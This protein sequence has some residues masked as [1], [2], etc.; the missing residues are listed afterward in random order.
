MG[1]RFGFNESNF[2]LEHRSKPAQ[3]TLERADQRVVIRS[4]IC[5]KRYGDAC[6]AQ[7]LRELFRITGSTVETV[8]YAGRPGFRF[9]LEDTAFDGLEKK[10]IGNGAKKDDHVHWIVF[11]ADAVYNYD[12][13]L[14]AF[15]D[16]VKSAKFS[17]A[18]CVLGT[19][20]I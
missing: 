19:Y 8:N 14:P 3:R 12:R 11:D 13:Y 15:M 20:C 2:V 5:S 9:T 6:H 4:W 17:D 18:A 10:M 7:L 16:I 1:G